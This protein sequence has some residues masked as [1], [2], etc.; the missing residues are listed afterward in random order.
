MPA[1]ATLQSYLDD[2]GIKAKVDALLYA[3]PN[4]GDSTFAAAFGAKVNARR[5]PFVHDVV[6]QVPCSPTMVGCPRAPI[7]SG[8]VKTWSYSPVPGT[9]ALQ[10]SGMP[11]QSVAWSHFNKIFPCHM[12]AFF[13][14]THVCA[15]GCYLSQ[16]AKDGNTM[17]KLWDKEGEG[18]F[19]PG[20]PHSDGPRQYPY[21]IG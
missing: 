15:Y 7:P 1:T 12:P 9:L 8:G 3:P 4:A 2:S 14:A 5:M 6:P 13:Q 19:C 18:S 11:Q 16:Y 21:I 10:P 20:Y 17:C